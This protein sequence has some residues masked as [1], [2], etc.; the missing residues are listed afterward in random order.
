MLLKRALA[1]AAIT[2]VG[3]VVLFYLLAAIAG[4]GGLTLPGLAE[5]LLILAIATFGGWWASGRIP[6][7]R[8][9]AEPPEHEVPSPR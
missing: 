4:A 9:P 2:L 3:F 7:L 1:A 5:I 6:A 8:A